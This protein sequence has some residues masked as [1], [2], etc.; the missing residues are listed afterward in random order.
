VEQLRWRTNIKKARRLGSREDESSVAEKAQIVLELRQRYPLAA[1]PK[2][3][4]L[5]RSTFYCQQKVL[6]AGDKYASLKERIRALFEQ[7]KGRY[8][9]HRITAAI[10]VP[11][12]QDQP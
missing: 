4:G 2:V 11:G 5:A 6:R 3:A 12:R 9:Y 7:H 10:S 8:G 1:V